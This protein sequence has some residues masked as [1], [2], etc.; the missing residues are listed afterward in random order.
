MVEYGNPFLTTR[1]F[2]RKLL[3]R[4]FS[5]S[6][7]VAKR[8]SQVISPVTGCIHRLPASFVIGRS[9]AHI[10]S[11]RLCSFHADCAFSG[12][13]PVTGRIRRNP[14]SFAI[15]PATGSEQI[16]YAWPATGLH[17]CMQGRLPAHNRCCMWIRR[18][19]AHH[20]FC[21]LQQIVYARPAQGRLY[22]LT[23]YFAG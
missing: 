23:T 21:R 18:L 4:P 6:L 8:P 17:E 12:H 10:I 5:F 22:R 14:A 3:R 1:R 15:A 9:P 13:R 7:C 2:F 11:C 20:R 16:L 19:P